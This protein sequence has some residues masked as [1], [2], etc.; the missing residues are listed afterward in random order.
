MPFRSVEVEREGYTARSD[1]WGLK[2]FHDNLYYKWVT[3]GEFG[4]LAL[5]PLSLVVSRIKRLFRF[6]EFTS[7]SSDHD[8]Q[9]RRQYQYA[10]EKPALKL[11]KSGCRIGFNQEP[12]CTSTCMNPDS[13]SASTSTLANCV[14][15]AS[16]EVLIRSGSLAWPLDS[17][18]MTELRAYGVNKIRDWNGSSV[19]GSV[20]QCTVASCQAP[21]GLLGNCSPDLLN[22]QRVDFDSSSSLLGL[23]SAL[24][25]YCDGT[26]VTV[27]ADVAGPGCSWLV[28]HRVMVL[29][30][31]P[32]NIMN[33]QLVQ[34]LAVNG[35]LPVLLM[36]SLLQR[37]GMGWWYTLALTL[38]N[39][40]LAVVID[41][42]ESLSPTMETVWCHLRATEK[43]QQCDNNP[44]LQAFC[45]ASIP[46]LTPPSFRSAR[47]A[48]I[49]PVVMILV[50]NQ[51]LLHIEKSRIPR[52]VSGFVNA[53]RLRWTGRIV[54]LLW[55]FV[56][57][58]VMMNLAVHVWTLRNIA[59]ELGISAWNRWS[60]GQV[61]ASMVWAPILG[62]LFYYTIC[63]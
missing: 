16:A 57:F 63:E 40:I 20:L 12:N 42:L 62:K 31:A 49:Y 13:R 50:L 28:V 11:L 59:E 43:V 38:G 22:L 61:V 39:C 56:E 44:S 10:D 41:N 4:V 23:Q 19:L 24:T 45:L 1:S 3:F 18:D 54:R 15:L 47:R 27:N 60:Y 29:S 5:I 46:E 37:V 26:D 58:L 21:D 48:H 55:G 14:T 2:L 35:V 30:K 51:D 17:D 7:N 52:C 33:S 25:S 8:A 34:I 9:N 32:F 6:I 36:Q 53:R